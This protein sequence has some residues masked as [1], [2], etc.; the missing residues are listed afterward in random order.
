MINNKV[1]YYVFQKNSREDCQK[2]MKSMGM[3]SFDIFK[4]KIKKIK[5]KGKEIVIVDPKSENK[6]PNVMV[7]GSTGKEKKVG[8][9]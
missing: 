4:Q 7:F 1:T 8:N 6:N 9:V 5:S 2:G 3:Q